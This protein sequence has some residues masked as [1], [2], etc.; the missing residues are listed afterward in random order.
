MA[1]LLTTYQEEVFPALKK[2]FGLTNPMQIPRIEKITCNMGVGEASK[3]A[4]LLDVDVEHRHLRLRQRLARLDDDL[5]RHC[6]GPG[7]KAPQ[8]VPGGGALRG[9]PS[10]HGRRQSRSGQNASSLELAMP[11]HSSK[12]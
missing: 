5:P 1:R 10:P 11:Y 7:L 3:N 4:K 6:P 12:P 8:P 2:E 9:G